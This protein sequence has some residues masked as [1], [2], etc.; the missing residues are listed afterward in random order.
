MSN[1]G[2]TLEAQDVLKILRLLPHR[3]PFL[4]IDRIV[5]IVLDQ[6]CTGVKNVSINEPH[7]QGHFP[8]NPIMP[9]VLQIEGMAQTAGALV[10]L[11]KGY[12]EPP[13]VFFMSIEKARFRKPV[14]P[15]DQVKYQVTKLKERGTIFK[16]DCVAYVD[17]ERVSEA[18]LT[19]MIN[20]S[21]P[22]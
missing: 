4:M 16:Y 5:D 9:G 18:E 14:V 7:F 21:L 12:K 19:A 6:S 2:K 13:P 22:E 1:D 17:G 11:S 10:V 3:Y 15:G 8:D 20:Q